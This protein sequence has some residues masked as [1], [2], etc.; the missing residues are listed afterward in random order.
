M[1]SAKIYLTV[2][3]AFVPIIL[4]PEYAK[5][6]DK[7]KINGYVA[8]GGIYT[9][10]YEGSDDYKASPLGAFRVQYENYYIET[11]GPGVKVN[12]SPFIDLDMGAVINYRG[13]RDS[14]VESKAVSRMKNIDSAIEAGAFA[15]LKYPSVILPRDSFSLDIDVTSDVSGTHD[16]VLVSFSPS[17][18]YF[19][20]RNLRLAASVSA[21]YASD[22]Y[23][24]T[25]FSVNSA[26]STASG[27][28][29]FNAGGGI[30]DIGT[31]LNA[32]YRINDKWGIMGIAGYSRLTGDFADSPI[33][34]NQGDASQYMTGIGV[35]YNF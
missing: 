23:A 30:K 2:L 35:S 5:A 3:F 21:T 24:N 15:K 7:E 11:T 12:L 1:T 17:Y 19:A 4:T 28:T 32:N 20:T 16:G 34:D 29:K 18:G 26:D 6:Y 8:A 22:N 9:P 14:D 10:D 33:T 31:T 27:L 13:K 25:Y